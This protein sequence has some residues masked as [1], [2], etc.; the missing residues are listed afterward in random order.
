[1]SLRSIACQ[2]PLN[3]I[4]PDRKIWI[5]VRRPILDES[6]LGPTEWEIGRLN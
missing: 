5:I 4:F 3:N 6:K 1:M 2:R